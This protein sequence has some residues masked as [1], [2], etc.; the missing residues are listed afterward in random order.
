MTIPKPEELHDESNIRYTY[1]SNKSNNS[2]GIKYTQEAPIELARELLKIKSCISSN[3]G[4]GIK[5]QTRQRRKTRQ[6]N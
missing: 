2:K 4:R 5:K 3:I 1:I 6:Q